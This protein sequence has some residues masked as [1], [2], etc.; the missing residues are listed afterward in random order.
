MAKGT[1]T[2]TK[3]EETNDTITFS[4]KASMTPN[5]KKESLVVKD[6]DMALT[7]QEQYSKTDKEWK[8]GSLNIQVKYPVYIN[9]SLY[10]NVNGTMNLS[11]E[12]VL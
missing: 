11:C 2:Y 9:D 3:T 6:G 12:P 1:A 8:G 7:G 10:S 5:L 4:V